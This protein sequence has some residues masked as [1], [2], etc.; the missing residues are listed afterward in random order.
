MRSNALRVIAEM[1]CET[2]LPIQGVLEGSHR[3]LGDVRL[4]L[5]D[6]SPL[7]FMVRSRAGIERG[8]QLV[9]DLPIAGGIMAQCIWT[10]HQE[11]GFSFE[12][13]LPAETL[14]QLSSGA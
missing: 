2:R 8:D 5:T 10:R 4:L 14:A 9:V 6:I 13:P 1:R 11:A 12:I 3:L 7:G